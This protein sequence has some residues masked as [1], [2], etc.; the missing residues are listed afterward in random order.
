MA[1]FAFEVP[2][3]FAQ[4][5][6]IKFETLSNDGNHKGQVFN[7]SVDDFKT[8]DLGVFYRLAGLESEPHFHTGIDPSFDP[9][10]LFMLQGK[11]VLHFWDLKDQEA[12]YS[13]EAGQVLTIPKFI[14]HDYATV[15]DS[16]FIELRQ[17]PYSQ[18]KKDLF[19]QT[20][21]EQLKKE[22]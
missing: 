6:D 10:V 14:L 5:A 17:L 9:Q 22:L 4:I 8:T 2:T 12:E 11:M 1:E 3:S 13:L 18:A 7:F 19:S 15:E 16:T 21:F 20:E